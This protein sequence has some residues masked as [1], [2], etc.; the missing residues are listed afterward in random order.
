MQT[1]YICM[2][3]RQTRNHGYLK[4][5]RRCHCGMIKRGMFSWEVKLCLPK[6]AFQRSMFVQTAS[7]FD[8]LL[9]PLF[10]YFKGPCAF[11]PL[12]QT[13]LSIWGKCCNSARVCWYQRGELGYIRIDYILFSLEE[14]TIFT[15][16]LAPMDENAL[17]LILKHQSSHQNYCFPRFLSNS[18]YNL[19]LRACLQRW[20]EAAELRGMRVAL[21]GWTV[22]LSKDDPVVY[23]VC[24]VQV[25]HREGLRT[26]HEEV[27]GTQQRFQGYLL[28]P[29]SSDMLSKIN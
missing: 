15:F 12:K 19:R 6:S 28:F 3:L 10:I 8:S 25:D 1:V 18:C 17:S 27:S 11:L 23:H 21:Q 7:C 29:A 24:T 16:C 2:K 14:H 5:M 9:V 4:L 22:G 13:R 20:W 26:R